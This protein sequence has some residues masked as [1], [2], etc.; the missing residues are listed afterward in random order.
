M[1]CRTISVVWLTLGASLL[2]YPKRVSAAEKADACADAY[3]LTQS[4][5]RSGQLF[6]ARRDARLCVAT[7]PPRLASD[8][9]KWETRITA[10]I[11]SFVV[12]ARSADGAPVAVDV[13]IDGVPAAFT[14]TGSIEAG[15]GPHALVLVHSGVRVEA[16][17]DLV[18]GVRNQL[19]E[20]TIAGTPRPF[21]PALPEPAPAP[22][23]RAVPVWGWLVGGLGLATLASGGAISIS[24]EVLDAQFRGSGGCAPHC[25]QTQAQEVVQRWVIGGTL[26]GVGTAISLAALFWLWPARSVGEPASGRAPAARFWL[27]PAGRL[28]LEVAF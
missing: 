11:P 14:E 4:K 27:D 7:C 19:V 5:Q 16:R 3:E 21:L 8:C 23:H 1:F 6:D 24:G 15:P 12:Q 28:G 26:M 9:S 20:V 2:V 17:V 10:Q 22:H 25:T 18:A 13:L